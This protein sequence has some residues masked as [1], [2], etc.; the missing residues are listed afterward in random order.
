MLLRT[1]QH[2]L[3]ASEFAQSGLYGSTFEG[4]SEL[5]D[6]ACRERPA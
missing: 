3:V 4:A 2:G 1:Q 5:L 6:I